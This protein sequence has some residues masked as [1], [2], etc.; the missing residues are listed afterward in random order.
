MCSLGMGIYLKASREGEKIGEKRGR[1][2]GKEEG[3]KEGKEEGRK[4]GKEEGRKEGRK[5]GK[6]NTYLNNIS[7]IMEKL[8]YTAEQAMDFLDLSEDEKA[9]YSKL[10]K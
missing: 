3:R 9:I 1:K 6:I 2:E 8:N 5:E 7:K 4:E 10:L